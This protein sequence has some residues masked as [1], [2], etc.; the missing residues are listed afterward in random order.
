M[1]CKPLIG[2]NTDY[3]AA[4]NDCP[5]YAYLASGYFDCIKEAGG[6]PV[7]GAPL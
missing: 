4:G 2:L 3:R 7:I 1:H 5:A 6:L